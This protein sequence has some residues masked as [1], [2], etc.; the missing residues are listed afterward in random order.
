MIF[1]S[2]PLLSHT[3]KL[4]QRSTEVAKVKKEFVNPTLALTV[5][6]LETYKNSD[7]S[8][9]YGKQLNPKR[10][11]T[12]PSKPVYNDGHDNQDNDLILYV[13][14][15]L[16]AKENQRY[17]VI[18]LLGQGTFGQV[19]RC[20]NLKTGE[21]VAVKVIKGKD[22]YFNQSLMEI[23]IL[24]MLN[25]EYDPDDKHHFI[26]LKDTF[27]HHSHLC[28]VFELLSVSLYDLLKQ[29]NFKG[30]SPNLIKVFTR[31]IL[32]ALVVLSDA[33]IIHADLKPENILLKD[34]DSPEIKI[35]DFGSAC[36][37]QRTIYTYI[38]S[39]FYRS[40]EVL[41]GHTY[42]TSVDMW[43]VGCILAELFLGLPLFPG[44]SEYNQLARIQEL[45]GAPPAFMIEHGKHGS[46]FYT[47]RVA[48]NGTRLYDLKPPEV[49]SFEKNTSEGPSKRYFPLVPIPELIQT[50]PLPKKLQTNAEI[51]R[52]ADNR[53]SFSDFILGLLNLN[54]FERWTPH[55]ARLHPFV[56]GEPFFGSFHPPTTIYTA[57]VTA[58]ST[59]NTAFTVQG[60]GALNHKHRSRI[61]SN[62]FNATVPNTIPIPI[63]HASGSLAISKV[64]PSPQ[65]FRTEVDMGNISEAPNLETAMADLHISVTP[66]GLPSSR[67]R[68]TQALAKSLSYNSRSS[69]LKPTMP[70]SLS[71]AGSRRMSHSSGNSGMHQS[72]PVFNPLVRESHPQDSNL[73][74][75]HSEPLRYPSAYTNTLSSGIEKGPSKTTRP[76]LHLPAYLNSKPGSNSK[77]KDPK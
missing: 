54:P 16:G 37:D 30:L 44:T 8:F 25:R 76:K 55:Q 56:T 49:Y 23:T 9:Q 67:N 1:Q 13:N 43:S 45:L 3:E 28:L 20:Q 62:T 39:R 40:P 24:D 64:V 11:L 57:P 47:R 22:A 74:L 52:E 36:H 59:P 29:N 68:P 66:P 27:I 38:Q 2:H 10:V 17:K 5:G 65:L 50:Y 70:L 12:K 21:L 42:S 18:D 69:Y 35:I 77:S 14:S 63:Q 31:Q 7:S 48:E 6:I 58:I 71:S 32:N 51:Q 72:Q 73:H 33:H 34:L 53:A 19:A 15:I 46:D 75:T 4:S 26:R 60:P 61:R 41:L